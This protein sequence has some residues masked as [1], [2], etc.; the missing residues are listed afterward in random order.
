MADSA[1]TIICAY[2][3]PPAEQIGPQ[4]RQQLQ[5][6]GEVYELDAVGLVFVIDDPDAP[7]GISA[8]DELISALHQAGIN[9][10]AQNLHNPYGVVARRELWRVGGEGYRWLIHPD[11]RQPMF[12]IADFDAAAKATAKAQELLSVISEIPD[13]LLNVQYSGAKQPYFDE[14]EQECAVTAHF[15]NQ[16]RAYPIPPP[17]RRTAALREL[18][19]DSGGAVQAHET[20]GEVLIID[21]LDGGVG[22]DRYRSLIGALCREGLTV[23]AQNLAGGAPARREFWHPD[24]WQTAWRIDPLSGQQLVELGAVA[25]ALAGSDDGEEI[26]AL[27][28]KPT[29]PLGLFDLRANP[30]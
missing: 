3:M 16:I 9:V 6:A 27:L 23:I 29:L 30:S 11:T 8:Y 5:S 22:I 15:L 18:I 28:R 14:P 20:A 2:P 4:L 7:D 21:G 13:G 10:L 19:E 12:T 1:A 25:E 17:A 24:G 26:L